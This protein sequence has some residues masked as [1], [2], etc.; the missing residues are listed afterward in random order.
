[1]SVASRAGEAAFR[2][3]EIA[4][5][6]CMAAVAIL[7][8]DNPAYSPNLLWAFAALLAFNLAYHVALRRQGEAWYVPMVSMAANT[9]LVTLVLQYSGGADSPFWPMYLIPIFT[10]CL[11]LAGRHVAFATASAAAFLACLYLSAAQPDSPLQWALAELTIKVAV[12]A[13]SASVTAQYAFRERRARKE[14][15]SARAELERLGA[16]LERADLDRRDSGGGMARFLA[17][18]VYDLN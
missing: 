11:Y 16:E 12:L 1:M 15:F 7:V 13:V 3:Q 4:F 5:S 6:L 14:L 2:N 17:G 9:V 10:A 18:L 8:K